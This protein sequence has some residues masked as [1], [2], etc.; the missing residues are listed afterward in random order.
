MHLKSTCLILICLL[1]IFYTYNNATVMPACQIPLHA[2]FE[3]PN[4]I[5]SVDRIEDG[6]TLWCVR[7]R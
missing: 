5:V 7:N 6:Y 1:H 4:V 3:G 2:S